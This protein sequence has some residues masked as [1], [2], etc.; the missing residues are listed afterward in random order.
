MSADCNLYR[1]SVLVKLESGGLKCL[2]QLPRGSQEEG[3][4]ARHPSHLGAPGGA[5]S[6]RFLP[7]PASGGAEASGGLISRSASTSLSDITFSSTLKCS[8]EL[9]PSSFL[10]SVS[11]FSLLCTSLAE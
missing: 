11:S 5:E 6:L 7:M 3:I 1:P 10:K 9:M 4:Q 2:S 8:P